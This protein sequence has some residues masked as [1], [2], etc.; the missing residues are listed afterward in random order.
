[1]S[2]KEITENIE[3]M[4]EIPADLGPALKLLGTVLTEQ[5]QGANG[6]YLSKEEREKNKAPL[7]EIIQSDIQIRF[8]NR[9]MTLVP[10]KEGKPMVSIPVGQSDKKT[11]A[12]IPREWLVGALIDGLLSI[13]DGDTQV[14]GVFINSRIKKAIEEAM[15]VNEDGKMKVVTS[16]L[17]T[18]DH[19]VEV[20]EFLE[21]LKYSFVSKS[22]GSAKLNFGIEFTELEPIAPVEEEVVEEEEVQ[23]DWHEE[24]AKRLLGES[25]IELTKQDVIEAVDSIEDAELV[26]F[27]Q[28]GDEMI[29]ADPPYTDNDGW[30]PQENAVE[31]IALMNEMTEN[32]RNHLISSREEL[33][34]ESEDNEFEFPTLRGE[35][36][37]AMREAW[38]YH[39]VAHHDQNKTI[40][41]SDMTVNMLAELAGV[42]VQTI[43]RVI[44]Y[45]VEKEGYEE[46][47]TDFTQAPEDFAPHTF[48]FEC[49]RSDTGR[50]VRGSEIYIHYFEN[51]DDGVW[52][53]STDGPVFVEKEED[54]DEIEEPLTLKEVDETDPALSP[55]PDCGTLTLPSDAPK[56]APDF[57]CNDCHD[58]RMDEDEEW[59]EETKQRSELNSIIDGSAR[60]EDQFDLSKMLGWE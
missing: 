53:D 16:K 49:E 27:I 22:A 38:I 20:A 8:G 28:D 18:H 19:P 5:Y 30:K 37:L 56:D 48:G 59:A 44:D 39:Q 58:I 42:N 33:T 50:Y 55:C 35:K 31:T 11:P 14:V 40:D 29:V 7:A 41:D 10:A 4:G 52:V 25:P 6:T 34:Q 24:A 45:I 43:K 46:D 17:P 60:T 32:A 1:M 36:G 13:F 54:Q 2:R 51:E 9:M 23:A 57:V 15:E 26:A 3:N 21:A 12:T 47:W